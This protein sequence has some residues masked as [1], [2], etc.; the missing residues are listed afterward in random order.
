MAYTPG[1]DI[2]DLRDIKEK[3]DEIMSGEYSDFDSAE[4]ALDYLKAVKE[5]EDD[6]LYD[7][8]DAIAYKQAPG[9]IHDDYFEEYAENYAD[10]IGAIDA[11]A[12]WPLNH[13]DWAEAADELKHDFI[14]VE[15]GGYTYQMEGH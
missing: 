4:D 11:N 1:E 14:E 9:L 3:R 10:D 5:L 13:I 15:F 6:Y 12:T 7:S 2:L 8:L